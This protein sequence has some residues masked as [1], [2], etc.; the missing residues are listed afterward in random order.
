MPARGVGR[1]AVK[2]TKHSLY[3]DLREAAR[4]IEPRAGGVEA[5]MLLM[6]LLILKRASD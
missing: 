2:T 3:R 4:L 1:R 6:A 5:V